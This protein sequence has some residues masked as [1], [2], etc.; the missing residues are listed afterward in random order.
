M[1]FLV[2]FV[3]TRSGLGPHITGSDESV[4]TTTKAATRF[5]K[6]EACYSR[7]GDKSCVLICLII[8]F[9]FAVALIKRHSCSWPVMFFSCRSLPLQQQRR[10]RVD[11]IEFNLMQHP[12]ALF[13][14]LEES[15]PP[16]VSCHRLG[17]VA[18]LVFFGLNVVHLTV[19][20]YSSNLF[21]FW[22]SG[23]R[24]CSGDSWSR[25]EHWQ[26]NWG[27]WNTGDTF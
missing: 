10:G 5:T 25:N 6:N 4:N 24:R 26:W 17:L 27:W 7:S 8:L 14:H 11:D 21:V 23:I 9:V 20:W 16:D 15:L 2:L 12:L 3:Q 13:P 18:K 19:N 22:N 1:Y